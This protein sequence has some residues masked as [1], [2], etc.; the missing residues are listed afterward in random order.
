MVHRLFSSTVF[1]TGLPWDSTRTIKCLVKVLCL[2][3]S[4]IAKLEFF[5]H[6]KV[7]NSH[8]SL[9]LEALLLFVQCNKHGSLLSFAFGLSLTVTFLSFDFNTNFYI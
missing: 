4:C 2:I 5:N 1:L 9:L 8:P 3:L 7:C 6:P